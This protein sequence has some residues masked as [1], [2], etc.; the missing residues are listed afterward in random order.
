MLCKRSGSSAVEKLVKS[1]RQ[2]HCQQI[3]TSLCKVRK[4]A[5][6]FEEIKLVTFFINLGVLVNP[7]R[8][9]AL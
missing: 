5:K 6:T 7:L 9:H 3:K 4:T 2:L 8:N 1:R